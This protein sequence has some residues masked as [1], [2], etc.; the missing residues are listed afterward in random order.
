MATLYPLLVM[1]RIAKKYNMRLRGT[2]YYPQ[3][4]LRLLTFVC[5]FHYRWETEEETEEAERRKEA[6]KY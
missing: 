5:T 6:S 2:P 1:D 3:V 4:K